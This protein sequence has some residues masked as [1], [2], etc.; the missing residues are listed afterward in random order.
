MEWPAILEGS[1]CWRST[2]HERLTCKDSTTR[3]L[4]VLVVWASFIGASSGRDSST[5]GD[6]VKLIRTE[7]LPNVPGQTLSV[8]TV[9][10]PPDTSVTAAMAAARAVVAEKP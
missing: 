4:A 8:V 10:Y 6:D 2:S 3:R 1:W 5:A 9:N 7:K